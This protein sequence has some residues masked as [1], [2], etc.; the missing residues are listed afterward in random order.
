M[1]KFF[2]ERITDISNDLCKFVETNNISKKDLTRLFDYHYN[3]QHIYP[4]TNWTAHRI[5]CMSCIAVKL[6]DKVK[7]WFCHF[8]VKQYFYEKA[9]CTC[10]CQDKHF[11]VNHD[12]FH[13]DSMNYLIYG[14]LALLNACLYLKPY[15]N[16]DYSDI[17]D[18]IVQ[19]VQPYLNGSKK[20][21]EYVNSEIHSDKQK[22]EY[23]KYWNP[24][25][26]DL[27]FRKIKELSKKV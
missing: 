1:D 7:I 21:I 12:F 5:R 14:S 2:I 24:K 15:T 6:R 8:L 26:A 27:F 13:R 3:N 4:F 20:H 16:Y 10:H 9:H 17:F 11:G 19:F 22:P 23:G 18:P 25:Y